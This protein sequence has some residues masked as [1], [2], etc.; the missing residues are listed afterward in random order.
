MLAGTVEILGWPKK[1][2]DQDEQNTLK[3]QI[4][5]PTLLNTPGSCYWTGKRLQMP[6]LKAQRMNSLTD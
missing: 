2:A 5:K 3:K 6:E 1:A 4:A